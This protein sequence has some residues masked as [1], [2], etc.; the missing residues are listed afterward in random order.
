MH[1]SMETQ[2]PA[3]SSNRTYLD[4][5]NWYEVVSDGAKDSVEGLGETAV[6]TW[7]HFF[8]NRAPGTLNLHWI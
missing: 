5:V 1:Y 3:L 8:D 6:R 4:S 7:R 2:G